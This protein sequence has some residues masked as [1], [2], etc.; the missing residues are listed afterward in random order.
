MKLINNQ[1]PFA[2][3]LSETLHIATN[4]N[5]Y[6]AHIFLLGKKQKYSARPFQTF[7]MRYFWSVELQ[8]VLTK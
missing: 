2:L 7:A 4:A 1:Q 6:V 8:V 5:N 3:D